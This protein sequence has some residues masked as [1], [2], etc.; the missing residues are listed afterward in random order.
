MSEKYRHKICNARE[1]CLVDIILKYVYNLWIMI[2]LLIGAIVFQNG[3]TLFFGEERAY[4]DTLVLHA[5]FGNDTGTVYVVEQAKVSSDRGFFLI[6]SATYRKSEPESLLSATITFFDADKR[7]LFEEKS[8]GGKNISFE[9]SGVY[10]SLFI[11][12]S[13]DQLN[14]NPTFDAIKGATRTH[15]VKEGEWQRIVSYKVSPN[16]RYLLFH[17]RN[18]FHDKLWDYIYFYDLDTGNDWDYVFPTCLSCKRARIDLELD[19]N[20][21]STVIHKQEHRVFSPEGILEDIYLKLQ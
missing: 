14:S 16:G 7:N 1:I 20:G 18:P 8:K 3:D 15:V 5:G 4:N 2:L 9:L 12:A 21:R 19:E 10:D 11:I 17:T 13:W 6:Y